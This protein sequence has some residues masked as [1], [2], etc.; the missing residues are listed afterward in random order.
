MV[1][2]PPLPP[3][4]NPALWDWLRHSQRPLQDVQPPSCWHH[5]AYQR[6]PL[7]GIPEVYPSSWSFAEVTHQ[8]F[9]AQ[10]LASWFRFQVFGP[11]HMQVV[12]VWNAHLQNEVLED[13]DLSSEIVSQFDDVL[14]AIARMN[15]DIE[16]ESRR[17]LMVMVRPLFFL[18]MHPILPRFVA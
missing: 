12:I 14:S 5:C 17:T 7:G 2:L 8:L 11:P 6:I 18:L 15:T 3:Q 4:F 9:V 1:V 16:G 13:L 10:V